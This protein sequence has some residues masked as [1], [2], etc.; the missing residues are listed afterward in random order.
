[1]LRHRGHRWI[2][3][4]ELELAVEDLALAAFR[5]RDLPDA[6]EPDGA[7]NALGIPRGT[8]KTSIFYHLGLAHYLRGEF[9]AALS[10]YDE[11]RAL[12]SW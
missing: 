10:A 11:C 8:D 6:V 4:R 7:P 1:L 12:S 9:A 5:C 2:T 3:L